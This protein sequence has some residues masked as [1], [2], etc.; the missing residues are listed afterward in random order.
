MHCLAKPSHSVTKELNC[1]EIPLRIL[2]RVGNGYRV[3]WE[4]SQ[5]E[6][7]ITVTARHLKGLLARKFAIAKV[8]NGLS[9]VRVI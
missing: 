5:P 3:V 9:Q 4:C 8:L 1:G 6:A 7:V 2:K